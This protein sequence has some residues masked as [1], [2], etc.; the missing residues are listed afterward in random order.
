MEAQFDTHCRACN[1][2]ID[3]GDEIAMDDDHGWV[4][5]D[6][7]GT[8]PAGRPAA[9]EVI[10]ALDSLMGGTP[11]GSGDLSERAATRRAAAGYAATV[12]GAIAG[13]PTAKGHAEGW[14]DVDRLVRRRPD[15]E[16]PPAEPAP[17]VEYKSTDRYDRYVLSHPNREGKTVT[18][19]R[20]TT[21]IKA[22]D[23]MYNLGEWQKGNV[24]LGLARRSDLLALAAS[25]KPGDK[26]LKTLVKAAEEAGG[27]SAKA[28]L[29]TALHGF[30]EMVDWGRPLTDV[31]EAHRGDIRAYV[32]ALARYRLTVVPAAIER[33]TMTAEWDGIAGKFDRIYRLHDGTY[34]IG[35]VKS[36]KVGYDPKV[37]FAQMAVYARGVNEVG[38]YDVAGK[39]WER[40]PFEVR[41]D[42]ALIVHLPAGAG[43]C[44][45]YEVSSDDM[46]AGRDHL[47]MCARIRRH[48][49]LKHKLNEYEP[50]VRTGA[51][52]VT[53]IVATRTRG[54]LAALGRVMQAGEA[55]TPE[56]LA[57]ARRHRGKLP[58]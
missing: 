24:A 36:G 5:A 34:A 9:P 54:D 33:I 18:L 16:V 53:A 35:D 51:D 19:S 27:G 58:E 43:E 1:V 45:V 48:R 56:L 25:L 47:T 8:A 4:H 57:L 37:M 42:K 30:T 32:E 39:C 44:T 50:P 52:W 41:T 7:A 46:D 20:C 28:N 13:E 2:P 15:D 14:L 23:D 21:V 11:L 55:M 10:D 6:C 40:L 29:G 3:E 49:K 26:S 22:A 12:A 38:V 31:P 17:Q